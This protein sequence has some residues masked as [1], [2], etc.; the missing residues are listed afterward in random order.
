MS[1]DGMDDRP[2]GAVTLR[3]RR[4]QLH[5]WLTEREYARLRLFAESDDLSVSAVIRHLLR[6]RLMVET[7]RPI[8][9]VCGRPRRES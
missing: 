2:P 4:R 1:E 9:R 6:E 3:T 5:V 8:C 7:G